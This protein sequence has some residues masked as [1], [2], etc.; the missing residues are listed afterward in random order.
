[1]PYYLFKPLARQQGKLTFKAVNALSE[2]FDTSRHATAIRLIESDHSPAL[3]VCHGPKGRKWFTRAPNV[4]QKWFP[5]ELLDA[6]S[7]AFGIQFGGNP[8]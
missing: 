7:F 1:M 2:I 4:P 8:G 3:L 5:Q 6:E